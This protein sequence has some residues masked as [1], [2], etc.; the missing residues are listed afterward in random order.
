MKTRKQFAEIVCKI[1]SFANIL[2][3][4][5]GGSL[6]KPERRAEGGT[7]GGGADIEKTMAL[8][9]GEA[10]MKLI[11]LIYWGNIHTISGA[12]ATAPCSERTAIRW[13]GDFIRLVG[14]D[15]HCG[16]LTV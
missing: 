11:R 14:R 6:R 4:Y 8:P 12:A 5:G 15:F 16:R 10:R 9:D 7:G 1:R 13:N 2:Y 3:G